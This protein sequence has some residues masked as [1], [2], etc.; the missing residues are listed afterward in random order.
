M[1]KTRTSIQ[2]DGIVSKESAAAAAH[3]LFKL[4]Q[5]ARMASTLN[6]TWPNPRTVIQLQKGLSTK[7]IQSV[8]L[9]AALRS[10]VD[11]VV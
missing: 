7:V 2:P 4:S 6:M 9:F 11:V 5:H 3:H 1:E 10:V 8:V